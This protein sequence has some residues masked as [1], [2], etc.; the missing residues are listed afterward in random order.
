ML[1]GAK[2]APLPEE[3]VMVLIPGNAEYPF[4]LSLISS[5]AIGPKAVVASVV[6]DGVEE[7]LL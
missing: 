5:S 6:Y 7:V 3:V 1:D 4:L 2:S